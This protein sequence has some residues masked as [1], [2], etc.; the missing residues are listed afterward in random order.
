MLGVAGAP[1]E[2]CFQLALEAIVLEA[3]LPHPV[4][5]TDHR[6]ADSIDELLAQPPREGGTV[7]KM[8]CGQNMT[9]SLCNESVR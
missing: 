3:E 7:L 4:H 5:R 2:E 1:F 6:L 8:A 9:P